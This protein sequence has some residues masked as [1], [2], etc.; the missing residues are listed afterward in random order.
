[1]PD[2]DLIEVFNSRTLL[3]RDSARALQ[4]AQRHGLPGTV[5]SDAHVIKEI[6]RAFIELPEFNDA[7]QFQQA[8]RQGQAFTSRTSPQLHFYNIR[9][10]LFKLLKR[11]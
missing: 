10:R 8:L 6:G 7:Q 1:M 9:N 3:L 5:G 2:V 11:S 4:L